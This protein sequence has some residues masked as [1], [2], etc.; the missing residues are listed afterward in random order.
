MSLTDRIKKDAAKGA[1][2]I[3]STEATKLSQMLNKLFYLDK[4]IANE[5]KFI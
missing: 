1:V 2:Q 5:A 4:D 3:E